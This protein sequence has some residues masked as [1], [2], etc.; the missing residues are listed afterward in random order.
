M[1]VLDDRF[2]ISPERVEAQTEVIKYNELFLVTLPDGSIP[3]GYPGGL[4]LYFR[5]TRFLSTLEFLVEEREPNLLSSGVRYSYFSQCDLANPELKVSSG[6][7]VP[8]QSLHFRF[9]RL[10]NDAFYQRF[11]VRN[12]N[13]FPVTINLTFRLGADFR[14]IFEIRGVKRPRRGEPVPVTWQREGAVFRYLGLDG[15]LRSTV[16]RWDPF[17][18]ELTL[19]GNDLV[20]QY[21]LTVPP[22]E[23]A[24]L[25]WKIGV[26]VGN[27]TQAFVPVTIQGSDLKMSFIYAANEQ[28]KRYNAWHEV[29]TRFESRLPRFDRMLEQA[30]SDLWV[31]RAVYPE[32]PV[33]EAGVPWYATAFGRDALITAWQTLMVNPGICRETLRFLAAHQGRR[34]DSSREEEPGKIIHEIRRGEMANCREI[35]HTPYY[36]SVDAT[37]W[38]II[39]LGDFVAWTKDF[40]FLEEMREPLLKALAWCTDY[41]DKDGDGYIEYTGDVA[42]GLQNQGWKDSWDGVPDPE[43]KSVEPPVAL[44][45]VQAYLYA[46]YRKAGRLLS[47]LDEKKAAREYEERARTLRK[48]FNQDFWVRKNDC[49]GL[50]LDGQKRLIPTVASNMGH[51]LFTGILPPQAAKRVAAKLLSREMF[52]GWGIRTLSTREKAYN[53]ISYH[54]GSVWPHDNS[55]IALG[56]RRYR[57]LEE[58]KVLVSALFDAA[59]EFPYYRFPELFC[60][61]S[62]R[63]HARPVRYPVACE[64]QAWAAGSIFLLLQACFGLSSTLDGLLVQEPV[65]APFLDGIRIENMSVHG[66]RVGIE[67]FRRG[68]RVFCLP[69]KKEGDVKIIIEA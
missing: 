27:R 52:S 48:R 50:A 34:V 53:S 25:Y 57:L 1:A 69:L 67:F 29:C 24:Y 12:Y 32:G 23:R 30:L 3:S 37:L 36:G 38:F 60:G 54:N 47:L 10:I 2:R 9:L 20:V 18:N 39:V 6:T 31:L 56:F 44:V 45:E 58:L 22:K 15:L 8:L 19:E 51:A 49:L 14:D 13:L 26:E 63:P 21:S 68:E 17:P 65:L 28:K 59:Y 46:A 42:G 64:P 43:G 16:I 33:I 66:G 55:I 7:V 62:R 41:G 11:R 40:E 4:G 61:F 35:L 5:D